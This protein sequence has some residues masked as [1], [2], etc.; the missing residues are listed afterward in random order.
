MSNVLEAWDIPEPLRRV[1]WCLASATRGW[2]YAWSFTFAFVFA[3]LLTAG[4]MR[5]V[6]GFLAFAIPRGTLTWSPSW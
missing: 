5:F 4:E 6:T 3:L 1:A 2:V